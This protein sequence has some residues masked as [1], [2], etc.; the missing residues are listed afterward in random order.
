[1]T[2]TPE[3]APQFTKVVTVKFSGTTGRFSVV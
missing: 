3:Y 1:M 2:I